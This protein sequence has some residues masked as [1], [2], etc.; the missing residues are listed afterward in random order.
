[1][2]DRPPT[3]DGTTSDGTTSDGTATDSTASDGTAS[4]GTVRGV[5]PANRLGV[6][7]V[8]TVS[9]LCLVVAAVGVVAV[10]AEV[11]NTWEYYFLME[12]TITVA[13][14]IA[15]ALAGLA[16]LTGL[17]AVVGVGRLDRT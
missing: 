13:T 14:P 17:A 5:L 1:M 11:L 9:A 15:T 8:V 16:L 10:A 7:A 12:Q 6:L 3:S 4:D 2:P